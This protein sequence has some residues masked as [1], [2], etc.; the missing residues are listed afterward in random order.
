MGLEL[1]A[2]RKKILRR[3]QTQLCRIPAKVKRVPLRSLPGEGQESSEIRIW[4]KSSNRWLIT[5]SS[6]PEVD[7]LISRSE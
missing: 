1:K 5:E 3:Q 6:I 2:K 4:D 7:T